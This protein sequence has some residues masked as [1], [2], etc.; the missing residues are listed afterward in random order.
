MMDYV[1]SSEDE[2]TVRAATLDFLSQ[3]RKMQDQQFALSNNDTQKTYPDAI[4]PERQPEQGTVKFPD[5]CELMRIYTGE[6]LNEANLRLGYEELAF[7]PFPRAVE[8]SAGKEP[9][10]ERLKHYRVAIIGAGINGIS[11][12]VHLQRLGIPYTLID[13]QADVGGTW[14]NNT[15]PGEC[16]KCGRC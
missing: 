6:D 3:Q 16:R 5:A 13:R 11:T 7:Q 1:L 4:S 9:S 14:Y 8:W 2:A 12:A 15:Y 10:A